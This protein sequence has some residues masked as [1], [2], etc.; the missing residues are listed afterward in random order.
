MA[1]FIIS[2]DTESDDLKVVVNGESYDNVVYASCSYY[3]DYENVD[4][5]VRVN[6]TTETVDDNGVRKVMNVYANHKGIFKE[7][8]NSI[9]DDISKAFKVK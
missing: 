6:I 7:D 8:P 9:V 1:K 2:G 3:K 4:P 5:K